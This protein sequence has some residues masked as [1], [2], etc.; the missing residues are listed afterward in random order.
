MLRQENLFE[1]F[2]HSKQKETPSDLRLHSAARVG[3]TDLIRKLLDSGR[4][5]PDSQDKVQQWQLESKQNLISYFSC[6]PYLP[7]YL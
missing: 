1:C 7:L 5:H 2:F 4:V 6:Q 3:D